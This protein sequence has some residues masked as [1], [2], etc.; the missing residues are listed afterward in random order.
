[1]L[2][3]RIFFAIPVMIGRYIM[4]RKH[5]REIYKFSNHSNVVVRFFIG[6]DTIPS[7]IPEDIIVLPMYENLHEGKIWMYHCG[8]FKNL[9]IE[10]FSHKNLFHHVGYRFF[11]RALKLKKCKKIAKKKRR[12]ATFSVSELI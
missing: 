3:I 7:P 6:N 11:Q 2:E 12:I 8:V 4:A 1:M 5:L 9:D 10:F